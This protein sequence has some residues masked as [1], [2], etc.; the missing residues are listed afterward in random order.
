[1]PKEQKSS[2]GGLIA[3]AKAVGSAAGK[4]AAKVGA[5]GA[6]AAPKAPSVKK[7]KPAKIEGR[8]RLPR[9]QKKALRKSHA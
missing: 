7:G 1:M 5:E 3:A 6:P 9:R 4:I 2:E 8:T